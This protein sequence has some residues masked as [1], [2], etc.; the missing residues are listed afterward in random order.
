MAQAEGT[1]AG[2]SERMPLDDQDAPQAK[3]REIA[4][5]NRLSRMTQDYARRHGKLDVPLISLGSDYDTMRAALR[6]VF[7]KMAECNESE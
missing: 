3:A 2:W 5:K 4:A 7:D 1:M 6:P